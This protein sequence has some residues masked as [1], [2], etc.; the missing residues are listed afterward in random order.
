MQ[1]SLIAEQ[2]EMKYEGEQVREKNN[3]HSSVCNGYDIIHFPG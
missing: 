2:N 3:H 1:N